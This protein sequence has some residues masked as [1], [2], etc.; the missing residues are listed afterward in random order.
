[1]LYQQD[2][3]SGVCLCVITQ[4]NYRTGESRRVDFEILYGNDL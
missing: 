3:S 2:T 1:M 4:E